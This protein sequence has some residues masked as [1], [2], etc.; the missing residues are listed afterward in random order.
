MALLMKS[1]NGQ[2]WSKTERQELR[3]QLRGLSRLS[4][5]FAMAALPFTTLAL[6]LVAWW[7][8]RRQ[9]QRANDPSSN[10]TP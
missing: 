2:R 8:D 6:P 3:K 9:R 1:R 5:Y 10:A 7:L 4:L